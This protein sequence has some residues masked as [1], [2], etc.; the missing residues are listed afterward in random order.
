MAISRFLKLNTGFKMPAIGFGTYM[1]KGDALKDAL[2]YALFVGYRHIDT[3][4]VYGNEE[5]I[6]QVVNDRQRAGKL[7][8]KD[9][10]I[11]SKVPYFCMRRQAVLES[12]QKSLHSLKTNYLDMLLIHHPWAS[13]KNEKDVVTFDHVD[14]PETWSA[15]TSVFKG[16]QASN[17]GVSNFTIKQLEKI[18]SSSGVPPANVQ[19]ECHAYLQQSRLKALC[20]SKNIIVSAYAPLGAPNRPSHHSQNNDSLLTDPVIVNI[21]E[22][23][24]KTPAQI[25][26]HFLLRR[27]FVVLPKSG[28][29]ARIKENLDCLN[30][31]IT[32]KDF[33]NIL[34]LDKGIRFFKFL[35]MKGHPEY[36]SDEDF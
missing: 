33:E 29:K 25:L 15:L 32:N 35:Y 4:V 23:Y 2:D 10:F 30:F 24:K 21:A 12:V 1:L 11:T 5:E 14:L 9:V 26:L 22:S 31:T 27:G 6:G 34:G 7:E 3:A 28:T 20:D 36:F 19:L 17:I 16:G 13:Q 18:I 8:R